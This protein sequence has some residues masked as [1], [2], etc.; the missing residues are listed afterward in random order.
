LYRGAPD[1]RAALHLAI[2]SQKPLATL[3]ATL[4]NFANK[5]WAK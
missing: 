4:D 5:A 1:Q 3:I 2:F